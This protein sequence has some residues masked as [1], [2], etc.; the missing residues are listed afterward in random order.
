MSEENGYAGALESHRLAQQAVRLDPKYSRAWVE[1]GRSIY[2]IDHSKP[3]GM[4]GPLWLAQRERALGYARRAV[5]LDP[6]NGDAQAF[7]GWVEANGEQPELALRRIRKAIE[8]NPGE[9][10]VWGIASLIY[11]QQLCDRKREIEANRRYLALEPLD[12]RPQATLAL[13]LYAIGD[14]AEAGELRR[15]LAHTS[16]AEYLEDSLASRRGDYSSLLARRLKEPSKG[17]PFPVAW[18]L[19]GLGKVGPAIEWLPSG[20]RDSLG[21]YWRGDYARAATQTDFIPTARWNNARTIVIE[22]TLVSTGQHARLLDIFD[23]RFRS[24]EEFDQRLNCHLPSHAAPVA[25]A[26]QRAGRTAEAN[27]LIS[28]AERRYRQSGTYGFAADHAGYVQ[29]LVIAGRPSEALA[30]L[31]RVQRMTVAWESGPPV[32]W[33]NLHDPIY[34]PIRDHPR[35]KAVERRI[36]A[37]RAKELRELAAA[38]V[39]I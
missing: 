35:F 7:L 10:S 15:N 8:L 24:V 13:Q 17:N 34:D 39:K 26:L 4:F 1:L 14:T 36:A 19:A 18:G 9:A 27:R 38:G 30:A 29:L 23:K 20:Y 31:D 28:L 33:L 2:E 12:L 16:A 5:E 21:A 32:V 37:W 25:V 3:E 11:S 22:R 6:K